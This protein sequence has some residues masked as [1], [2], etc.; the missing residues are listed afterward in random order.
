M[1][2]RENS[3]NRRRSTRIAKMQRT[4]SQNSHGK[5]NKE[6]VPSNYILHSQNTVPINSNSNFYSGWNRRSSRQSKSR[7]MQSVEPASNRP[8]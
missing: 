3:A 1:E 8:Q 5:N 7:N 6:N 4:S 2:N